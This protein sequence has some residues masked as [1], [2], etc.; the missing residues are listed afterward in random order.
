MDR[1]KDLNGFLKHASEVGKAVLEFRNPLLVGDYDADGISSTSIGAL[2]LKRKG[3]PFEIN[4]LRKRDEKTIKEI[5]KS[6]CEEIVFFDFGSGML[7]IIEQELVG[8][9]FVVIDH[10][11]PEKDSKSEFHANPHQFGFSGV[12]EASA[13]T[14]SYLC[15]RECGFDLSEYAVVGAVGDM[16]DNYGGERGFT[17][18]NKFVLDEALENGIV[19]VTKDLKIFG[20]VSRPLVWFLNYSAEPYLPGLTNDEK[21]CAAF[22][23]K[24][25]IPLREETEVSGKKVFRWLHYYD[26]NVFQRRRFVS[27][28]VNYCYEKGLSEDVVKELIGN[29]YCFL[30]EKQ[31]TELYDAY[32]FSTLLNAC[33]RHG[34]PEVGIGVCLHENGAFEE[35]KKILNTHR[36]FIRNGISLAKRKTSDYGAFYF[37][38]GRG[39]VP[40]T[41]VGSIAGTYFN[42]GLVK[43]NKPIIAFS[44]D[45][46]NNI[47]VSARGSRVLVEQGLDLTTAMKKAA[48][49]I[50]FGGG[51][52]IAAGA[53]IKKGSEKE[54]LLRCKNII[55]SQLHPKQ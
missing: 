17:G 24:N 48:Y 34:Q 18:L 26:L 35:A 54:F 15:F 19:F 10:H 32:E 53:S 21:A 47:K 3:I 7:N 12:N 55:S 41:V 44:L 16:Q 20:R 46:D 36:A 38:D 33:G 52:T 8:K 43:R 42:S 11:Q 14:V 40:P 2:A 5:G 50:G 39:K 25:G 45:E 1:Q 37:L 49:G 29:V 30:R 31:N 4:I 51:H 22:L 27:A 28:L 6:N 13:S 9:K 23:E